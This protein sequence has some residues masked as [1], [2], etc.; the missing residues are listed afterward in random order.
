M[1]KESPDNHE[2]WAIQL[3]MSESAMTDQNY[4]QVITLSTQS[5]DKLMDTHVLKLLGLRATAYEKR[6]LLS[7]ALEDAMRMIQY[8]PL[9]PAGYLSAGSIHMVN[10]KPTLAVDCYTK[11]LNVIPKDHVQYLQIQDECEKASQ[12]AQQRFDIV[13]NLPPE[14]IH[15]IL[16]NLGSDHVWV[17]LKVSKKWCQQVLRCGIWWNSVTVKQT[18]T[19]IDKAVCDA[20]PLVKDYIQRL[21]ITNLLYTKLN[22]RYLMYF[23]YGTFTSLKEL[24]LR[25]WFISR[26][27]QQLLH[28]PLSLVFRSIF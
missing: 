22:K 9:S 25:G 1:D 7:R 17:C 20:I 4:L 26:Y 10:G 21:E 6:G 27:L 18:G 2:S 28:N 24:V 13:G 14:I 8:V 12:R 3:A 23:K 19:G 11:A 16:T 5:L 15:E